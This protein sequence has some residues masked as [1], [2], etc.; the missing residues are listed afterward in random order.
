MLVRRGAVWG[1]GTSCISGRVLDGYQP[2]GGSSGLV[3]CEAGIVVQPVAAG[4]EVSMLAIRER[5]QTPLRDVLAIG[6]PPPSLVSHARSL[7]QTQARVFRWEQAGPE[8]RGLLF[9]EGLQGNN[10][11]PEFSA[12]GSFRLLEHHGQA[13]EVRDVDGTNCWR[14]HRPTQ[15]RGTLLPLAGY[16]RSDGSGKSTKPPIR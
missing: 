16:G 5:P 6:R 13:D 11:M 1:S 10:A 12:G 8:L 3:R 4:C 15:P 14:K 2:P 7:V 9:Q